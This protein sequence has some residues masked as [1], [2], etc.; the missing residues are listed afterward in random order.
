M[1]HARAVFLMIVVTL[2]WSIARRLLSIHP[3]QSRRH[4]DA[5][6]RERIIALLVLLPVPVT[7]F[8]VFHQSG[9]SLTLFA[10]DHTQSTCVSESSVPPCHRGY[11]SAQPDLAALA[12]GNRSQDSGWCRALFCLLSGDGDGFSAR[13]R[14]STYQSPVAHR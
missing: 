5:A 8:F 13:W 12:A 6:D 11:P 7:F 2:L 1:S 3:Q 4:H 9:S 10:S 14:H